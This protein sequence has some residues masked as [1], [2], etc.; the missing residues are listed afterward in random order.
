MTISVRVTGDVTKI[1][2]KYTKFDDEKL[3][4]LISN[5]KDTIALS[6]LYD[7][8]KTSL[9][10]FLKRGLYGDTLIEEIYNDVML[11][12]WEKAN[13]FRGESKVST[14]IFGIAYHVRMSHS[15]KEGR[16]THVDHNESTEEVTSEIKLQHAETLQDALVTLSAV[17]RE[18][19]ELAYFHGYNTLE[20]ASI[21]K[22]PQNTVK[23]RL[24]HA[25]KKLKATIE[26]HQ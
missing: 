14:W 9:G 16:H 22:C 24:F 23:T 18:V 5:K 1:G 3:L 17:H 21:V 26:A 12:V 2:G 13:S 6:E 11:I 25:R 8:Y 20:I 10:R 7:R 4:D 19:I 15:R